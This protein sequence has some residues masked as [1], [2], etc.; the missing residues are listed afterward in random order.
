MSERM[1]V[2]RGNEIARRDENIRVRDLPQAEEITYWYEEDAHIFL[3][4]ITVIQGE[5]VEMGEISKM[6]NIGENTF[7]STQRSQDSSIECHSKGAV[8]T[9]DISLRI[10]SRLALDESAKED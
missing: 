6:Q 3:R 9:S 10:L 7:S 2:L 4:G 5:L 1:P 8:R